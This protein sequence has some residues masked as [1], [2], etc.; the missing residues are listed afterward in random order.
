MSRVTGIFFDQNLPPHLCQACVTLAIF[1]ENDPF[2]DVFA[3]RSYKHATRTHMY[4][5]LRK[6]IHARAHTYTHITRT[7]AHLRKHTH[8]RSHTYVHTTRADTCP[9]IYAHAYTSVHTLTRTLHVH[10]PARTPRAHTHA[11]IQTRKNLSGFKM[12]PFGSFQGSTRIP[13]AWPR[14]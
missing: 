11:L 2:R 13:S 12:H 3:S 4:A 6:H 10:I 9:S 14:G 8:A 5:H 1:S 7:H